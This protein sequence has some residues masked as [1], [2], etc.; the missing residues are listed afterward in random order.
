MPGEQIDSGSNY[1]DLEVT[2][3][4]IIAEAIELAPGVVLLEKYKVESLLGRGGMGSVYRIEHL[5][6]QRPYA[7]K[8]LNKQQTSEAA[9]RRFE[10]EARAANKL[11]HPNLVRVHDYGL[12]PDG[13]PY[14]IMDLIEGESL[15]DIL[16]TCGR[17]P[18]DKALKIFIQVGFA[19]SYAHANGVIHR[20]IKPSNIMVA[21]T[22]TEDARGVLVKVVDFGIA[23][24]TGKDEFNQQTLTKT[25]EVFG[26]PLYMSPEQCLGQAIDQRCDLY[27][28]GCVIFEALTGAPPLVGEN[29]LSTM[30]KHQGE[31]PLS[32]KEA[33]MGVEFPK[34]IEE[35]VERLLEKEPQQR[36]QSAQHLTADLVGL[37]S[38]QISI[39]DASPRPISEA[40]QQRKQSV[41]LLLFGGICM[42]ALGILSGM[43]VV[44]INATNEQPLH[45]SKVGGDFPKMISEQHE[46]VKTQKKIEEL[47][48]DQWSQLEAEAGFFSSLQAN[49]KSRIF[50]FPAFSIGKLRIS[51]HNEVP[52]QGDVTCPNFAGLYFVPNEQFQKHPKLFKK[53]RPDDVYA[54]DLRSMAGPLN[55]AEKDV[56]AANSALF[57]IRPLK[58]L[59]ILDLGDTEITEEALLQ[60]NHIPNLH[61]LLLTRTNLNGSQI[62]KLNCLSNLTVLKLVG[63]KNIKPVI[64]RI[65]NSNHLR[66]LVI[67]NC[68]VDE[69]DL[70]QLKNLKLLSI[71]EIANNSDIGDVAVK[72]I[73]KGVKDIDLRDCPLTGKC[74]PDLIAMKNLQSIRMS[75]DGWSESQIA[76]LRSYKKQVTLF[77]ARVRR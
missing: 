33:S 24:L 12:L 64:A 57:G 6:L 1:Q 71:L 31:K 36:Y 20:D 3:A 53:F 54:L 47:K 55:I 2:A 41:V 10:I 76:E 49:S 7:L 19:L 48:G 66:Y 15:S 74:L 16:K 4:G 8:V 50:H 21:T 65:Q 75:G 44:R 62:A 70:K 14:F 72:S 40:E 58:E 35:I 45:R 5:L 67:S 68:G 22:T 43:F 52:A 30:M 28:L 69:D 18:L 23:K 17:L 61:E 32:L 51:K 26:S 27:S 73:P 63:T 77:D 42:I 60:I 29:A 25:G 9:W 13:Q 37:D 59:D 34:K 46:D 56:T 11:D 39:F 38:G